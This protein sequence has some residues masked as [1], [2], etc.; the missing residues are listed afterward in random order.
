MGRNLTEIALAFI[1]VATIALIVS[2][3]K[4]TTAVIESATTGFA[5]LLRTVTLQDGY[6]NAFSRF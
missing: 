2:Q 5:G 4:G 6:G 1:S 3:Y